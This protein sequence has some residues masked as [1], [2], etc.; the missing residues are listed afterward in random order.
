[1]VNVKEAIEGNKLN[2]EIVKGSL[3]KRC[4]I[5][6]PG[7]YKDSEWGLK[8]ELDIEIDGKKKKWSPN[9]DTLKNI[10]Y[11]FGEDSAFWVGKVISLSTYVFKGKETVNG[12][13]VQLP[14][15]PREEN[16]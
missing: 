14:P 9:K 5:I 8:L 4:V 11:A 1:M 6:T 7:E 15:I 2:A 13:P 12:M 10:S 3:S 16:I